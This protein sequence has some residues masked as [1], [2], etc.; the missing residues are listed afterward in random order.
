MP[1]MAHSLRPV[2]DL[3]GVADT[4]VAVPSP[5]RFRT[6]LLVED[7]N[8]CRLTTRWFLA[9]F[10]YTVVP[11]RSAEE[12]LALF[13]PEIHDLVL[14]DNEMAALSGAEMAHII[15]LRSPT[16]PVIMYSGRPPADRSCLDVVIRKPAHLLKLKEAVD[17]AIAARKPVIGGRYTVLP[18]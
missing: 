18:E 14:T 11:A 17:E 3:A 8:V 12:A 13:V 15:K 16:T 7:E 4:R 10:G 2:E 5:S 9:N 6:I 1:T